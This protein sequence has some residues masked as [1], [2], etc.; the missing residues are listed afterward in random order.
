MGDQP[1]SIIPKPRTIDLDPIDQAW[2]A[3]WDVACDSMVEGPEVGAFKA[4][5]RN[6]GNTA[7]RIRLAVGRN[8]PG[9]YSLKLQ[10]N[11]IDCLAPDAAGF[12]HALVTLR[13]LLIR[14]RMVT[15]VIE[16]APT[17]AIR[18]FHLN[19]ESYRRMDIESALRLM[20]AAARLKLNTLLVEYGPRFPFEAYPELRDGTTLSAGDIEKLNESAQG[21]GIEI[22]PLQQS[23]A[24]LEYFLGHESRA[25]L[26]ERPPK[27]NLLCPSHPESLPLIKSLL[28]AVIAR[29][30]GGKYLHLGGDEAR[31]IGECPRCRPEVE[32]EGVG[33]LYGRYMGELARWVLEQGRRPIIWDDTI[34]AHPDA[35]EHLPRETIIQYWDYIAVADPSPVLIPRMAHVTGAPR[36]AHDWSWAVPRRQRVLSD[37]QRGVINAYS[38]PSRLKSSLGAE[39]LGEFGEYLGPDFPKWMKAL[40]YI[41]Y[42]QAKGFE[43]ITSPTGLGNGDS[44]DGIPNFARFEANIR[45]H[46]QRCRENGRALGIVTTAWYDM[47]P[48]ILYQPLIQTAIHAW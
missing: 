46:A 16:D 39:Y 44:A 1:C 3:G 22:I 7:G 40:P 37:M 8:P 41:E 11:E 2:P 25:H 36:V 30:P 27:V 17:L 19:F 14:P 38:R 21:H 34:C 45:T 48:E 26:R 18:G 28:A 31:K 43:V 4:G 6:N 35:L 20:E 5:L 24:H 13:Q 33:H 23:L 15:G 29:H 12:R 9:G 32:R 10:P 47:P 42:Y